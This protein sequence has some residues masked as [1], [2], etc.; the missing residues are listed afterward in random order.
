MSEMSKEMLE[1][2][3]MMQGGSIPQKE[4]DR[5]HERMKDT[6]SGRGLRE[7]SPVQTSADVSPQ[8]SRMPEQ[9]KAA[10]WLYAI[11]FAVFVLPAVV[12]GCLE[13]P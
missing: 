5:L 12:E 9:L 1:L 10:L 6:D 3:H 11:L 8:P 2:S 13:A 7:R 4:M